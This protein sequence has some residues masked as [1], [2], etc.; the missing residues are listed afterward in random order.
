MNRMNPRG[1]LEAASFHTSMPSSWANNASSLTRA[2][3]TWRKAFSSSLVSSASLGSEC[4]GGIRHY[5]RV[6]IGG[7]M[8]ERGIA[9]TAY[10]IR[11]KYAST[12]AVRSLAASRRDELERRLPSDVVRRRLP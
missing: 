1:L 11:R 8:D 3:F 2:M 7:H 9:A 4:A 12:I 5:V 10:S 6:L